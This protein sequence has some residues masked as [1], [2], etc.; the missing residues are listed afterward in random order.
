MHE[1]DKYGGREFDRVQF[2]NAWGDARGRQPAITL[3]QAVEEGRA[4]VVG[5]GVDMR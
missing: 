4:L 1:Y 3:E 2:A 5:R